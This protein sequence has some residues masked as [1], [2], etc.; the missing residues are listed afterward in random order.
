[1]VN[2][3]CQ[4]DWPWNAQIKTLFLYV[5]VR[6]F[7]NEISISVCEGDKADHPSQVGSASLTVEGPNRT[8]GGGRRNSTEMSHLISCLKLG[9]FGISFPGSQVSGHRPSLRDVHTT[10]CGT[11]QT[12]YLCKPIPHN[13]FCFSGEL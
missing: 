7:P 11:S 5:S 1:M 4:L 2:S 8:E 12:P 3:M 10:H 6:V 9:F 13:Q